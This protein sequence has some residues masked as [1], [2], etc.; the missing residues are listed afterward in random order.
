MSRFFRIS[1]GVFVTTVQCQKYQFVPAF[2]LT[3]ILEKAYFLFT[4]SFGLDILVAFLLIRATLSILI[5]YLTMFPIDSISEAPVSHLSVFRSAG[6]A[7]SS[8]VV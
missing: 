3:T 8:F 4:L 5:V 2:T 6:F 7:S 1:V